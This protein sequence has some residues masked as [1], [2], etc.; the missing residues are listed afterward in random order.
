MSSERR[1]AI[2]AKEITLFNR[3]YQGSKYARKRDSRWGSKCATLG[4]AIPEEKLNL[5][6]SSRIMNKTGKSGF[7]KGQTGNA[8]GRPQRMPAS[9]SNR[10]N[11]HGKEGRK[12]PC[13][14]GLNRAQ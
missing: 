1:E 11:G 10:W 12:E 7:K 13:S 9:G 8:K 5:V 6:A 14:T 2:P 3:V 4:V